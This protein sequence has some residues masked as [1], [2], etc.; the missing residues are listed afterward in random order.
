MWLAVRSF[1]ERLMSLTHAGPSVKTDTPISDSQLSAN[2]PKLDAVVNNFLHEIV[3]DKLTAGSISSSVNVSDRVVHVNVGTPPNVPLP[4]QIAGIAIER[5]DVASV[6]RDTAVFVWDEMAIRFKLGINTG[7]DDTTIGSYSDLQI[8]DLYANSVSGD[9][10]SLTGLTPG[11]VGADA[12]GTAATVQGNLTTHIGDIGNPHSVTKTQVGLS[13]VP[14][15][16][17]TNASN[18]SSGTLADARYSTNVPLKNAASNV[19]TGT[20]TSK[21][22]YLTKSGTGG[23]FDELS[24]MLRSNTG[25]TGLVLL[26]DRAAGVPAGAQLFWVQVGSGNADSNPCSGFYAT[27][28]DGTSNRKDFINFALA[29]GGA[30]TG[31]QVVL[32]ATST[33]PADV[34]SMAISGNLLINQ[35]LNI[36]RDL[37]QNIAGIVHVS[38]NGTDTRTGLSKYSLVK[39]F[40]TYTA[41][42]SAASSGDLIWGHCL[43]SERNV[44]WKDGVNGHFDNGAGIVTT[45]NAAN[46]FVIGDN[47]VACTCRITG[48]GVFTITDAGHNNDTTGI[49]Q[50][51]AS[52]GMTVDC[53]SCYGDHGGAICEGGTQVIKGACNGYNYGAVVASSGAQ[54]VYGDCTGTVNYGAFCYNSTGTQTVNGNVVGGG[55]DGGGAYTGGTQLVTGTI[56]STSNGFGVDVASGGNGTYLNDITSALSY[57]VNISDGTTTV[58]RDAVLTSGTGSNLEAITM[59]NA[60]ITSLKLYNCCLRPDGTA[61]SAIVAAVPETV[62]VSGCRST[63]PIPGANVTLRGDYLEDSGL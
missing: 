32:G 56:N 52:S 25:T 24:G 63:K 36:T 57:A 12:A 2:I 39:P 41:A 31:Y 3:V 22:H 44:A 17:C 26:G 59:P 37:T 21:A 55:V 29:N 62:I 61:A 7:A 43:T 30:L 1:L 48:Y 50:R 6:L 51:H 53:L 33:W 28:V 46:D 60:A 27:S 8:K 20:L 9:G 35:D 58:I 13:N 11:Q 18:I 4:T 15:T 23:A 54:T 14:N 38:S 45:R 5:G 49:W 40:A 10:S 34:V 42:L 16:D 19:F 47:N